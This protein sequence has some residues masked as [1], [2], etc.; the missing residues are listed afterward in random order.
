MVYLSIILPVH[1][2]SSVLESSVNKVIATVSSITPSFEIIIAE[3][4]STDGTYEIARRIAEKNSSVKLLHSR[5]RLGRGKAL[6]KALRKARGRIAVYMDA[7][8]SS[9]PSHLKQLI[10]RIEDG[11]SIATGSRLMKGSATQR[12]MKR[13]IASRIFNFLVRVLLGSRIMDHQCGFKAFRMRDVLPLLKKVKDDYWFW[14]TEILVRA[15]R[16]GMRV[17]EIPIRWSHGRFTKVSFTKDVLY[18]LGRILWLRKEL[19]Q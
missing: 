5:K 11:A 12:P 1:N 8:L 4:G 9:H 10:E 2:E 17:D 14:D 16:E 7:D 13:E 18:M 15:Q 6:K 19:S 3:D